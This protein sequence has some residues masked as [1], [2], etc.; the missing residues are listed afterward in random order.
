V[1]GFSNFSVP[2]AVSGGGS[3][4][5]NAGM[6]GVIGPA[7]LNMGT[8]LGSPA[9]AGTTGGLTAGPLPASG[10]LGAGSALAQGV[11]FTE[12][13]VAIM[14]AWPLDGFEDIRAWQLPAPNR[15][16]IRSGKRATKAIHR[17]RRLSRKSAPR[18]ESSAA[19]SS[20]SGH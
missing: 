15:S 19:T 17:E 3:G 10:R 4:N 13:G 1:N 8:E 5:F 11:A 7:G 20:G 14:G 12:D 18:R 16:G 2:A 6:N 9:F